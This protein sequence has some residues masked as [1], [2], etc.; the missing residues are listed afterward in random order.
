[1][2]GSAYGYKIVSVRGFGGHK[3]TNPGGFVR[4]DDKEF[5]LAR[6]VAADVDMATDAARASDIVLL[7]REGKTWLRDNDEVFLRGDPE[8]GLG[9]EDPRV[10]LDGDAFSFT[11]LN[12]EHCQSWLL[13]LEKGRPSRNSHPLGPP[14]SP[15]KNGYVF[16]AADG[17]GI[18][19][20]RFNETNAIQFFQFDSLRAAFD[21]CRTGHEMDWWQPH[22]RSTLRVQNWLAGE[23]GSF[24][25]AGFGTLVSKHAAVVHFA[26]ANDG[27]K[28]Y[29]TGLQRLDDAGLPCGPPEIIAEPAKDLPHGDVPN[30]IYTTMAW[31]QG[32]E[33]VLWSGHDDSYIMECRCKAP[34]WLLEG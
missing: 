29:V 13:H 8:R 2:A 10:L 16:E 25:H 30:V 34:K 21:A 3:Y 4:R 18:V 17:S 19:V 31:L 23:Q 28:Y 11:F 12:G 20:T 26:R 7:E 15:A 27:G 1:M 32:S 6:R 33:L 5:V 22:Q 14:I 9:Y 24:K